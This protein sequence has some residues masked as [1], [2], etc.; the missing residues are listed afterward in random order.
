MSK[1]S[2]AKANWNGKMFEDFVHDNLVRNDFIYTDLKKLPLRN[3]KGSSKS[4]TSQFN[5][6]QTIYG[7]KWM[8]DFLLYDAEVNQYLVIECK[9]QQSPGSVD[10][11][12]PYLVRNIKEQSPYPCLVLLDG[13]GYKP[14]AKEWLLT[15]VDEKLLGV[16]N[17]SEF[18]KWFMTQ[19]IFSTNQQ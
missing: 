5:L 1:T 13:D 16:L 9:W 15:Q 14:A 11:K 8:V 2:G 19:D 18:V 6:N 3:T 12:Y 10:E 17:M 7:T 4:F